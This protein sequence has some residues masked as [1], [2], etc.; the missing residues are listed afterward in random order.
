MQRSIACVL[1][2]NVA[3][4]ASTLPYADVV[5][6][7][8]LQMPRDFGSH[9]EFRTE[10]WYVTGWLEDDKGAPLGMQ[11]TFFR[12]R[13]RIGETNASEFAPRQLLF[14]HAAVAE[15]RTGRLRHEQRAARA[16]FG[17]AE[18]SESTTDVRI[19]DWSLRRTGQGYVARVLA[20]GFELDLAFT[21]TQ[22]PL[23]QG[24]RG[25]SRKGPDPRQASYYYSEP[26]LAVSGRCRI[27]QRTFTTRG[28]AW[29]DH[30]WSSEYLAPEAAGWDWTGINLHDGSALMAFV[31]RHR[32]GGMSWAG[33]SLRSKDGVTTP[34]TPQ[35]VRFEPRRTWRSPRTDA[36]YPVAVTLRAAGMT[37]DLE[38]LFDD[39]E[40]D[41]RASTGIVYWEGATRALRDGRE[42][43]RGYLELTGYAGA[44]K[45]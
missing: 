27:E 1:A 3:S 20:A 2:P 11:I 36:T 14:A 45:L 5:A 28:R 12:H 35:D 17:L 38:P 29:C 8:P 33:G 39:Q 32:D 18:A 21:A 19:D 9:P 41:A 24:D 26:H 10:W 15:P 6:G 13:P 4:A 31:I 34:F 37:Y 7:R 23:A 43:G 44:V 25:Y 40:L 30:E 16:G 42:V 22:T